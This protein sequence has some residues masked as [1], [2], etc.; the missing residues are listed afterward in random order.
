MPTLSFDSLP[1]I[2]S[3]LVVVEVPEFGDEATVN[4]RPLTVHH[5]SVLARM[6]IED[7]T[8]PA[9]AVIAALSAHDDKGGLVFGK[10]PKA[11]IQLLLALPADPY[12]PAIRRI[13]DAC[14]SM[15]RKDGADGD[16]QKN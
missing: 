2:D 11:A 10:T 14:L 7:P 5:Q 16:A 13:S 9:D 6:T 1:E 4:V 15:M 12:R 3:D 8:L